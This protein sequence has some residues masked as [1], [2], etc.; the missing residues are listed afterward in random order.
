VPYAGFDGP[1]VAEALQAGDPHGTVW[2]PGETDVS[3]RPGWFWHP[4]EDGQVRDA[5]NLLELYFTSVG[6]NSKLLLNVPPTTQGLL[7]DTDVARLNDFAA[8]RHRIFDLDFA[9]GARRSTT[10]GATETTVELKLVRPAPFD[11]LRLEEP[12]EQ[13]QC[14]ERYRMEAWTGS[15][16]VEMC[17]GTTV[18]CRKL[19]RFDPATTN[20]VR[21]TVASTLDTPRLS[22]IGLHKL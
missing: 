8:R 17:Q 13:G 21:V 6:R 14:I 7:H 11:V 9:H 4:A 12:I 15:D 2:R 19:D 3:I 16:W 5:D 20:R 18:G 10:P 1:G 22:A